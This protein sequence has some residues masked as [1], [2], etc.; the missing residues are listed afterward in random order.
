MCDFNVSSPL[1]NS[2][3]E[4]IK[5]LITEEA[6]TVPYGVLT[7]YYNKVTGY[8]FFFFTSTEGA[9]G[10]AFFLASSMVLLSNSPSLS[11][12]LVVGIASISC[13]REA[14]LCFWQLLFFHLPT[15]HVTYFQQG[16]LNVQSCNSLRLLHQVQAYKNM[17]RI[18]AN[19][20]EWQQKQN[21]GICQKAILT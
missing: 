14:I 5:V 12:I 18:L 6:N 8:F 3:T 15:W 19:S 21:G 20:L 16:H 10:P 4:K 17:Q 1:R 11:I 2:I 9:G 13:R 7:F